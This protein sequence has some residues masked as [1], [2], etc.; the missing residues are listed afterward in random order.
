[1]ILHFYQVINVYQL[2]FLAQLFS[3]VFLLWYCYYIGFDDPLLRA[4]LMCA[5]SLWMLFYLKVNQI[6]SLFLVATLVAFINSM[7]ICVLGFQLSFGG[8]L[9]IFAFSHIRFNNWILSS[10]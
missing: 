7:A 5:L 3:L 6:E 4:L 9:G 2:Q 10:L 8:V 1:M